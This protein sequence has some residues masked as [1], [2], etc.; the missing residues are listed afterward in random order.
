MEDIGGVRAIL[1]TQAQVD[2]V[3]VELRR[4]RRWTV[5]RERHYV[6]GRDPGP[7]PDGYR[8]VHMV[9]EK[10]GCFIEIQLRTPWQDAWAQS[11]EEDTRRLKAGL[12]F[13][14]GPA[15]LREYHRVI[16]EYFEMREHHEEVGQDLLDELSKLFDATRR[17]YPEEDEQ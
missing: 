8:A 15:D 13:G 5:K 14:V 6:A 1:P 17:Y 2:I 9:V 7:K 16:A 10:D 3:V 4:Q 12:K 11:V